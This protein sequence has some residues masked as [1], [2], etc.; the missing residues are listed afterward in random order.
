MKSSLRLTTL[1][2]LSLF[3]VTSCGPSLDVIG[4]WSDKS[5]VGTKQYTKLFVFALTS[6]MVVR[7]AMENE[8]A[9]A[10]A[11]RGMAVVKS[12]DVLPTTFQTDGKISRE[13]LVRIITEN[14]CDG[15][16]TFVIKDVKEET[17][18]VPGTESYAPHSYGMYGSYYGYYNYYQPTVYTPGYYTTDKVFFLESNFYDVATESMIWSV[19]SESVNPTNVNKFSKQYVHTLATNLRKN[20]IIK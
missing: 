11:E 8:M 2:C 15:V 10:V 18:Y 13:D 14:G 19:Q 3:L 12:I 9:A 4:I 16:M 5:K 17:R 6:D 7:G 1:F 20:G